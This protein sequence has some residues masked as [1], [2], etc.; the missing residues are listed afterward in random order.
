MRRVVIHHNPGHV[1]G[2]PVSFPLPD[3]CLRRPHRVE[4]IS[5]SLRDWGRRPDGAKKHAKVSRGFCGSITTH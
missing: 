5:G 2:G 1:I 3:C 4:R